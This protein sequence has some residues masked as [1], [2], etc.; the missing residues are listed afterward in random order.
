MKDTYKTT[1]YVDQWL[2]DWETYYYRVFSYSDLGGISYCDA[3]SVTPR[4]WWQPWAN[5]LAYYNIGNA[6]DN[7][8]IYD[9]SGNNVDQTWNGTASYSTDVAYDRVANFN[10]N[11]YTQHWSIIDFWQEFTFITLIKP[12]SSAKAVVLQCATPTWRPLWMWLDP[13]MF[14]MWTVS[15]WAVNFQSNSW[16]I[17]SNQRVMLSATVS[18]SNWTVKL[19]K[20]W[21][22]DK[23][24]TG[25]TGS[26]T[27]NTGWSQ[28]GIG[29]WR[30]WDNARFDWDFKLFIGE[31]RVWT[32]QEIA[33]LAAE[34]G[35]TVS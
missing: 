23:T 16:I 30:I 7:S 35:F 2:T 27:Y 18:V 20:N 5:T 24:Y 4:G 8:T 33:D 28:L 12:T 21:V 26:V 32:D 19:Y 9:Q 1:W 10:S 25:Q 34:Y 6:D 22:L 13:W 14:T 31:D 11:K 3:V 17:T 29:I 15:F